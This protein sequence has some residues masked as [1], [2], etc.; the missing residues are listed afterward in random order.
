MTNIDMHILSY[1]DYE[2]DV[3]FGKPRHYDDWIDAYSY[4]ARNDISTSDFDYRYYG[5]W[6]STSDIRYKF[7]SGKDRIARKRKKKSEFP[8]SYPK[9]DLDLLLSE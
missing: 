2:R 7:C 5:K 4:I 6:L 9:G 8:E 1:I 3:A